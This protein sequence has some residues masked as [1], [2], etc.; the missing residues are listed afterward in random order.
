MSLG[1]IGGDAL[2]VICGELCVGDVV[3]IAQCSIGTWH[4]MN[5]RWFDVFMDRLGRR[6][7]KEEEDFMNKKKKWGSPEPLQTLCRVWSSVYKSKGVS[8]K[9]YCLC[10]A[11]GALL[12]G[13]WS[14]NSGLMNAGDCA[15]SFSLKIG[16]REGGKLHVDVDWIDWEEYTTYKQ[17][18]SGDGQ[19]VQDKLQC[20]GTLRETWQSRMD[21]GKPP[22]TSS[23]ALVVERF[24]YGRNVANGYSDKQVAFNCSVTKFGAA[25]KKGTLAKVLE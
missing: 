5:D 9:K 15:T 7:A 11:S 3:A 16:L 10:F 17:V 14:Y 2:H 12:C 22:S 24:R 4:A 23:L 6:E 1:M 13:E 20:N 8:A 21:P 19:M 18:F 25:S